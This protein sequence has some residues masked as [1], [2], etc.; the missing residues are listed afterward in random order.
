MSRPASPQ[1]VAAVRR[2]HGDLLADVPDETVAQLLDARLLDL[3]RAVTS[4]PLSARL[5]SVP[6]RR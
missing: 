5:R 6:G 3:R 2:R 1:A 4:L